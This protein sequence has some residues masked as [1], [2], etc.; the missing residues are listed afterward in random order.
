M[1][2]YRHR[3]GTF[4]RGGFRRWFASTAGI[5]LLAIATTS[6][7][8]PAWALPDSEP[9]VDTTADDEIIIIEDDDERSA[10][11]APSG[12]D[13]PALIMLDEG[14]I[15]LLDD[16]E[17]AI[18]ELEP[19]AED[20]PPRVTGALGRVWE[21]L[22]VG[23]DSGLEQQAQLTPLEDAPFRSLL[24]LRL[25]SRL[26]PVPN[27]SFY[28]NGFFRGVPDTGPNVFRFT[29]FVDVY[30][31][32]AKI[33]TDIGS[34]V[35]GRLVVPWGRTQV[36]ALGDRLNPP[37]HRRAPGAFA[38]PA[39]RKQPQWGVQVRTSLG[40]FVLEGVA[41]T[42]YEPTEGSLAAANQGGVRIAR[43]QTALVRSPSRALG[44]FAGDDRSDLVADLNLVDSTTLG[45]RASRRV[46][47]IDV[48]ASAVYGIDDVPTLQ[49][50]PDGAMALAAEEKSGPIALPC[51]TLTPGDDAGCLG[52]GILRHNRAASFSMDMSW[53][54][55][56]AILRAEGVAYPA[57]GLLPGKTSILVDERG[58]RSTQ[59]SQYAVALALEAGLGDWVAGSLEVFDVMWVDV[60]RGARLWGVERREASLPDVRRTVHRLAVGASLGGS[61][62]EGLDWTVRGEG[63]LLQL[64]ALVSAELRYRL[65]VFGLYV[66]GRALGF[67]GMPGSPGWM[68]Q[69]ASQLAVFIGEGS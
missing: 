55:G 64:D 4:G 46:G 22:Y 8:V 1:T 69:D 34:V 61:V 6:T 51:E 33:N 36:A 21:A 26:L 9:T 18:I 52:G 54:L 42:V 66:G 15:E 49:L 38:G 23:V 56:L 5:A 3:R 28:A 35:V 2:S 11:G 48:G 27:L 45:M 53:G 57:F 25:E 67:V 13:E 41:L 10:P 43:Y 29:P 37:D 39:E 24:G 58:L 32:Y 17:T 60:P 44:L 59:L 7:A 65:P 14:E 20:A 47:D 12:D 31:A 62:F 19:D 40:A 68:R 50:G 30:E 16:E 63:G